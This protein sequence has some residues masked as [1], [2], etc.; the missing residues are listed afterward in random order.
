MTADPEA[1]TLRPTLIG[2]ETAPDDYQVIWDS[3]PIGRILK[4]PGVP[5]GGPTGI[6]AWLSRV[7][8][9]RRGIAATVATLTSASGASRP[10]GPGSER[11]SQ[12]PIL[13]RRGGLSRTPIGVLRNGNKR[14]SACVA[15]YPSAAQTHAGRLRRGCRKDSCSS[16]IAR[17]GAR[18]LGF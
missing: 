9:S 18:I 2:G 17:A 10:S 6:G 5:V 16:S 13:R 15:R 11:A 8:P 12:R 3:L 4:Q 14:L 1:L 7:G